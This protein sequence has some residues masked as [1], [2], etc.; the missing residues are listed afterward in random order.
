M[1]SM[2]Q[3]KTTTPKQVAPDLP[4]DLDAGL[5]RLKLA[6][7]RR[8]AP[9]VLLTATIQRWA[10]EQVLRTPIEA[11]VAARDASN[12]AHRLKAAGFPVAKTLESF[13]VAA[14]SIPQATF[15]YLSRL[16]WV[17]AQAN[18]AI[19]G[20]VVIAGLSAR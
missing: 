13:D 20:P 15:D 18:L 8:S 16:E 10:P 1:T 14:S 12:T 6:T 4:A 19:I 11:E 9:E 7:V 3:A 2:N 5:R 17:R